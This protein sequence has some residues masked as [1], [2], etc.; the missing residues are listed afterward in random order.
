MAAAFGHLRDFRG[1]RGARRIGLPARRPLDGPCPRD[2]RAVGDQHRRRRA[3]PHPLQ[4]GRPD[5]RLCPLRRRRPRHRLVAI[6]P[7]LRHRA[8]LAPPPRDA[9]GGGA[10][11]HPA[12]RRRRH[13]MVL[14]PA[15]H[16]HPRPVRRAAIRRHLLCRPA[17]RLDAAE[18]EDQLR[19]DPRPG[20]HPEARTRATRPPSPARSARS[21]SGSSRPRRRSRW[22]SAFRARR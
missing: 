11:Q 13:R 21:A 7:Q 6:V 3:L 5:P 10:A 4:A 8:R 22:R 16:R 9:D 19:P 1:R 2:R 20:H 18:A 12:G 15:R 17:G 14:A